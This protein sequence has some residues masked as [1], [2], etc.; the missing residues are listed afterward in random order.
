[1]TGRSIHYCAT[2]DLR[3]VWI[4]LLPEDRVGKTVAA[5][6]A[7]A[8]AVWTVGKDRSSSGSSRSSMDS[9][10]RP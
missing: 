9:W 8:E 10:E 6:A 2:A 4:L 7:A 3:K 5:E 1:M